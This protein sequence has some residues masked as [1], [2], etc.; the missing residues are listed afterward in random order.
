MPVKPG[1]RETGLRFQRRSLVKSILHFRKRLI[2]AG[3]LLGETI[4]GELLVE[5]LLLK[6]EYANCYKS[7]IA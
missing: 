4:L 5:I 7:S 2:C 3:E 6:N 1:S